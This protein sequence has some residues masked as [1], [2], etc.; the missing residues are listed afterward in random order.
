MKNIFSQLR[1]GLATAFFILALATSITPASSF[2]SSSS[3]TSTTAPLLIN[4]ENPFT[5]QFVDAIVDSAI[6]AG[7]VPGFPY[8]SG[9]LA[10]QVSLTTALPLTPSALLD[11]YVVHP[12]GGVTV[13]VQ[14]LNLAL[15]GTGIL[16][17]AR[18]PN[19][20][21]GN[22]SVVIKITNA[23]LVPITTASLGNVAIAW[24]GT[25]TVQTTTLPGIGLSIPLL[26]GSTEQTVLP[27]SFAP[28]IF[29]P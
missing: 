2:A 20:P 9:T 22:Y 1:S 29:A 15:L 23:G 24:S 10:V 3:D 19:P 26:N 28:I 25:N 7:R 18:I 27:F 11:A 5:N 4:S 14:D 6:L 13:I 21:V 8:A 12:D 16:P 17:V